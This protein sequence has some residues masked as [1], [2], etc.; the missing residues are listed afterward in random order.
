VARVIDGSLHGYERTAIAGVSNVGA[1]RNWTGSHFNQANWYAF[2]RLAWDPGLDATTVAEQ[3][4]RAT[5]S[6]DPEVVAALRGMM[7]ASREA[8]VNYMTPL[9][10]VH[11]M[12]EGHH[13]GPGP[14][15]DGLSRADW[16]SVYYHRADQEGIGFDRTETGSNAVEQYF[17]PL[18]EQ[19][20]SREKVP[21]ELLLF[22]HHVGWDEK[23]RTGRTLWEELV[24][25]YDQG[26]AAVDDMRRTWESLEGDIDPRRFVEVAEFLRI[27]EHEAQWWRDAALQYFRGFTNLEI[28]AGH[29]APA[30]PLEFYRS[31]DCPPDRN[32]PRCEPVYK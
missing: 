10:I 18:R 3:W 19:Y 16:T 21:L 30:H 4:I 2:G 7:M 32:K 29:A 9:G 17:S 13:Y 6:N 27:Q 28:P 31:L 22:F 15:V 25:R 20:A 23:L 11:I 26:I 1:D 14:W 24:H 5:F 12:A 8:V